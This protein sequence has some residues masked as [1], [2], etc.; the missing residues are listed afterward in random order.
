MARLYRRFVANE[1]FAVRLAA[2]AGEAVAALRRRPPAVALIDLRLPDADGLSLLRQMRADGLPTVAVAMTAH[3]SIELAVEAMRIGAFDFLVKPFGRERLVVTLRNAL[4]RHR[5][6]GLLESYRE[7]FARDRLGGLLG[8]SDAMQAVY[9]TIAAAARSR[10][11]V[12]LSGASGTGKELAARAV[13]DLSD[14]RGGPFVAINCAA[15]PAALVESELFGH[16]KGAFTG[17]GQARAGAAATANG[18]TLFL[19]EVTEMEPGIQAKLL[20]FLQ[21][22]RFTPLGADREQAADV[23]VLAASNRRPE[24]AMAEG[25]L[26][27][28]LFYRLNVIP[29]ELPP[30]C[31][32]DGDAL[33]IAHAALARAAKAEGKPFRAISPEAETCLLA[34]AWPGNVRELDN[35]I[36]RAVVL[37]EGETITPAMLPAA[38]RAA[39][40]PVAPNGPLFRK[41]PDAASAD[42]QPLAAVERAAIEAALAACQASVPRAA[43]LL[44]VNPST[45]YRK[46]QSWDADDLASPPS[47]LSSAR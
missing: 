33:L 9:R 1:G 30:L 43:A 20:R 38:V 21:G 31:Q 47:E 24:Q 37:H 36:Q 40:L 16:R 34:Y 25:R 15:L 12:F 46:R 23:R 45:L 14:R 35:V 17:A 42:I 41:T 2:S 19:D 39:G 4:E 13:H 5:L 26:R 7:E 27:E 44:G 29:L 8:G 22:G 10:A 11:A 28:D 6:A 18:G 32:R 3:G